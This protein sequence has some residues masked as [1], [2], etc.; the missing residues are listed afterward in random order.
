MTVEKLCAPTF[1]ARNP[2]MLVK[3]NIH[4]RDY[5]RVNVKIKDVYIVL[6]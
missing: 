4:T 1:N 2:N 6:D 3:Q 5:A